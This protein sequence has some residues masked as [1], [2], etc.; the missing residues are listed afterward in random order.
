MRLFRSHRIDDFVSGYIRDHREYLRGKVVV[1]LPAGQGESSRRLKEAGAEVHPFGLFPATFRIDGLD[2][3]R[4]DMTKPLPIADGFAD[5]VLCQ[6]G[7]EHLPD[8]YHSLCE[9]CRILRPGGRLLLTTPNYSNMRSRFSYFFSESEMYKLM[10]PNEIDSVWFSNLGDGGD[11]LYFGHVYSIGIQRLRLFACL[12]GLEIHKIH[13]TAVNKAS[14]GLL[15]LTWPLVL[16]VN[17]SAC[18]RA[19][20][21]RPDV[22]QDVRDRVFG[23][24]F[25]LGISPGLLTWGHLMIEFRKVAEP[26]AARHSIR[27]LHKLGQRS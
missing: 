23:E 27:D 17:Y 11:D 16:L 26:A 12:A 21:K 9:L 4:A 14:L 5:F 13:P 1:D 24:V 22:P 7:I 8:Q 10:P 20:R 6:E 2:C 3:A 19:M 15:L 25:R 18:R